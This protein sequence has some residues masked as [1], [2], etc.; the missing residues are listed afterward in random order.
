MK[1]LLSLLFLPFSIEA[2]FSQTASIG[3]VVRSEQE[4]L[5][6]VNV[7]LEGTTKG[8]ATDEN[9]HFLIKDVPVGTYRLLVTS[10]GFEAYA[11]KVTVAADERKQLDVIM[12]ASAARMEEMVVTGT[13][14]RTYISDSPVKVEVLTADF[15]KTSPSNSFIEA[16]QNVNGIQKQVNCG[17]CGTNDIHING[18]EG[19]YTLV[20]IDGM[21]IV[22]ALSSVYGFNGI[23]T[24]LIERVEI[25][26][27]PSSTLYGTEAVGGVINIITKDVDKAPLLSFDAYYTSHCESSTD[28]T[29]SPR[30][31][32]RLKTLLSG[33][34]FRNN[35]RM[36]FNND[37][38][39]DIPLTE[40]VSLFNKWS[41]TRKDNLRAEWAVRYY[42]EDRFGGELQWKT[43]NEGSDSVYGE[44]IQTERLE[45]IGT[46]DLPILAERF[47][48]DYSFNVHQQES[49]YGA[50]H[51]E[52]NQQVFFSN[53]LWTKTIRRHELLVGWTN[54]IQTYEDNSPAAVSERRYIPG[55]FIQDEWDVNDRTTLLTGT[56]FDYHEAHG[57]IFAPRFNVKQKFS[58]YTTVRLN[59]GTG[60]R[61]V[62]LFTED[63]AALT[64]ARTVLIRANLRPESSYNATLN[65][66]HVYAVGESV[67]N[68]DV[69]VFY[70]LFNNKIIPDYDE[71]PNLI[72]YDNLK[73]HGVTRGASVAVEQGFTFP[74]KI[75]LGAT[76]QRVFEVY[77]D[78]EGVRRQE[79]QFFV[80]QVSATYGL[81]YSFD[82]L[83]LTVDLSGR[84]V[85]PQKLP[86]YPAQFNR[87]Q[88][89]PWYALSDIQLTKKV[90]RKLEFYAG[91]KNIFNYTQPS[92][93]IDPEHPFGKN[94][95]TA[96]AYGPLQVRRFFFGL[97][98][99][100]D[101]SKK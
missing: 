13:M 3:G 57:M 4:K 82:R 55:V 89:S 95:D 20:L 25:V 41:L 64:G 66:H 65:F 40:R 49:Y 53:F 51:Y 52:A 85:G 12:T 96:F 77:K 79:E 30:V 50:T 78:Q 99:S 42:N 18:M 27:G 93:L 38:F 24:S 90:K 39:T 44:S 17:V 98:W 11:K 83:R 92:P 26:K 48:L 91:V 37:N 31:S 67:G 73:G 87:E 15:F 70:T 68:V 9:G 58:D 101:R 97:R 6:F 8:A 22:S 56:R 94:F 34:F 36:D 69:D 29:I 75:K 28:I 81:S 88:N 46:Y 59:L 61:I 86:E 7:V 23:P 76:Y 54:R 32:N 45:V 100:L 43:K 80:P 72:V 63:H 5:P 16:I 35:Y 71:D 21:P 84:V 47:R 14:K 19:P 33:N 60:F 10:L 74:L 62:N 2:V 1:V